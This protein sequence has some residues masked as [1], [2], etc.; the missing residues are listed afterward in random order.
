MERDAE[1]R[2]PWPLTLAAALVPALALWTLPQT[3]VGLAVAGLRAA[4]GSR[5]RLVRFGPFLQLLV[6]AP[7][8]GTA[9]I[10]LGVVA[11][12]DRPSLIRHELCHL[13][14]GLWLGWA[15]LPV[16]GLEYLLVGHDRSPHERLTCHFERTLPWVWMECTTR[17]SVRP[18]RKAPG[19]P[20]QPSRSRRSVAAPDASGASLVPRPGGA[21]RCSSWPRIRSWRASSSTD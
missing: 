6:H 18:G 7:G 12:A 11:F 10:S 17:R 16:Y 1:P 20:R 5:R 14:T 15:Y 9:G 21:P 8:P 13:I 2:R 3:L 4:Q 19:S